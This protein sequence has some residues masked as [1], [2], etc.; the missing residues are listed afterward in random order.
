MR[1]SY[2]SVQSSAKKIDA[3]WTT[4]IVDQIA[5]P[6][7]YL[8][9]NFTNF[10]ANQ[11]TIISKFLTFLCRVGSQNERKGATGAERKTYGTNWNVRA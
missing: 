8:F 10:S 9:A 6:L 1:Y 2:K 3:W 4:I 7:T 11:I 5:I